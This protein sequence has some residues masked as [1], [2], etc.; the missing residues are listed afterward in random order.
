MKFFIQMRGTVCYNHPQRLGTAE[1]HWE[2]ENPEPPLYLL[3]LPFLFDI[4]Q[5]DFESRDQAD[6]RAA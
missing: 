4:R 1:I 2:T 3:A 5:R 6:R